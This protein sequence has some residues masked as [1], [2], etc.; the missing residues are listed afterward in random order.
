VTDRAGNMATVVEDGI[1]IDK[2]PPIVTAGRAPLANAYGWNNTAVTA[3]F[4][5]TD[6]LSGIDGDAAVDDVAAAEGADQARTHVFTDLAG[7]S[8]VATVAGISIDLTP[9]VIT[10]AA[11]RAPNANGWYGAD[12]TVSYTCDDALAG[13][14]SCS[15]AET[16]SVEGA[17]LSSTGVA[18]DLAGNTAQASLAGIN[19]DWTPPVVTCT[20]D[21]PSIW[22]PNGQLVTVRTTVGIEGGLSGAAGFTLVTTASSEPDTDLG[23]GD[24][25]NDMQGWLLGTPDT[26]GQ[27][28]AER[29]GRG[30]GRVYALVYEG[31]DFAGNAA[32][33]TTTAVVPHD[34]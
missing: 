4:S 19:I 21:S 9:P 13:V 29:S 25:A 26:E 10:A 23:D 20:N 5:A 27:L 15:P 2:T 33:C 32:V 1:S 30:P 7:N 6:A 8:A 12:V 16:L 3:E 17:S 34:Q 31:T 28:R 14:L 22:P 18:V 24:T 11:D